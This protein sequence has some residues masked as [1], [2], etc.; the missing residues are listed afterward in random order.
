MIAS[1]GAP[2]V[3]VLCSM[4][5]SEPQLGADGK[6]HALDA[7]T[8][9]TPQ[10][11]M[12]IHQLLRE[13]KP[14]NSLEIGLAFGF[15]TIYFLAAIQANGKGHHTSVDPFQYETWHGVGAAREQVLGIQSG[16]FEF[17]CE[18][19]IQ[20]LARFA[21]EDRRFG[22]IFIDGD[23]KFDGVLIDFALAS[24]VCEP[25]GHIILDDMWMPSIQRA[26]SFIRR[27]R[28]DFTEVRTQ[29]SR[30]SVFRKT[31]SDKRSWDHFAQF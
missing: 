11:G 28:T 22:V 16:S 23:H 24:L 12:L 31:D 20:A 18:T 7:N 29:L 14:E 2:F 10:Q 15:S 27:N 13:T 4:Y 30:V 19:S 26:A 5:A 3:D 17:C 9:I 6:T 25:G 21:R 1:I 8:R